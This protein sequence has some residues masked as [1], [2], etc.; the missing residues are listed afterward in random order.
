VREGNIRGLFKDRVVVNP[1]AGWPE[2]LDPMQADVLEACY[3]TG[4]PWYDIRSPKHDAFVA[5]YRARFNETPRLGS[6]IGYV[7]IHTV[8]ALLRRAG[9]IEMERLVEAFKELRV[10]SLF[11]PIIFRS[12]DHQSTLGAYVGRTA[13][14][15]DAA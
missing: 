1:L 13:L 2:Y 9:S 7:F 14:R 4:Y 15:T 8:S 5:Q 11:G 12:L 6:M 10:D 3:V